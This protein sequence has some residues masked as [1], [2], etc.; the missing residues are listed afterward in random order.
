MSEK[1]RVTHDLRVFGCEE[2]HNEK[3]GPELVVDLYG[4]PENACGSVRFT[5]TN[6][7]ELQARLELVRNW[8]TEQRSV[9]LITDAAQ[10]TLIDERRLSGSVEGT[11]DE[12]PAE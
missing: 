1:Y 5:F 10:I 3:H 2:Q 8:A 7:Y 9:A 11:G 6:Y 12:P 4:G